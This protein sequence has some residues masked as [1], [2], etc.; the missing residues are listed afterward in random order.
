MVEEIRD[1][2]NGVRPGPG[3][4][5]VEARAGF[6]EFL[7]PRRLS[8]GELATLVRWVEAGAPEGDSPRATCR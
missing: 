1:G 4:A 6:G 3:N 2:V 8:D 5:A 7:E